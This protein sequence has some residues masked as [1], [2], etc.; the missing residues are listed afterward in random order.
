MNRNALFHG[1]YARKNPTPYTFLQTSLKASR[2]IPA[3]ITASQLESSLRESR[4]HIAQISQILDLTSDT[5]LRLAFIKL[6]VARIKVVAR[7]KVAYVSRGHP[8]YVLLGASEH[9]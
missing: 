8:A 7:W 1:L 6:V 5:R 9:A 2:Q 4:D 3:R